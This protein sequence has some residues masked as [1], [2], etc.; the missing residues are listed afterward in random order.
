MMC[1]YFLKSLYFASQRLLHLFP[2]SVEPNAMVIF[3]N[4]LSTFFFIYV[5]SYL[6]N[7]TSIVCIVSIT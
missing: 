4:T 1:W 5:A 7:H 2:C 3:R 6:F